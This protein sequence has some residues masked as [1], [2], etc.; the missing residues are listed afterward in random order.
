[1]LKTTWT[2]GNLVRLHQWD[3]KRICASDLILNLVQHTVSSFKLLEEVPC[4]L[5]QLKLQL[6]SSREERTAED[7]DQSIPLVNLYLVW[8][9]LTV[10]LS[11]ASS[12]VMSRNNHFFHRWKTFLWNCV[13][14]HWSCWGHSLTE[15]IVMTYTQQTFWLVFLWEAA[16]FTALGG[17]GGTSG[18]GLFRGQSI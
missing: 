10:R 6:V 13:T 5:H 16:S 4:I 18:A 17:V 9:F 14:L 3:T 11:L 1:M 7:W 8:A 15:M 2:F 12:Y